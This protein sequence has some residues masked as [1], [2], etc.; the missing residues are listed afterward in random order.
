MALRFDVCGELNK[1]TYKAPVNMYFLIVV[2][3]LVTFHL[4][5]IIFG[6]VYVMC[7]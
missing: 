5:K 2:C 4:Q 7:C 1:I 3:S 6:V